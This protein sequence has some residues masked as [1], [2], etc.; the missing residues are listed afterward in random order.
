MPRGALLRGPLSSLM[1]NV[2]VDVLVSEWLY[3]T[4]DEDAA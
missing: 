1:F 4:L 3:Q 2:C